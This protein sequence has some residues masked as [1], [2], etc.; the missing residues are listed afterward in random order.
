MKISAVIIAL[1]EEDRIREAIKTAQKVCD[2]VLVVDGG[3]RD[4]TA[5]RASEAGAVVIERPFDDFSAQK[6]FANSRASYSWILSLDSDERVSPELAEEI[7]AL[8]KATQEPA[9]TAY[10]FPRHTFYLGR[11]IRHCWYPD[12]KP[13]LFLKARVSWKG[14]LVHEALDIDGPVGS[15]H[16]PLFHYSYRD[17]SDH[18]RRIDFYTSRAARKLLRQ[19]RRRTL[20]GSTLLPLWAFLRF[21]IIR[22]GFLDGWPGFV[23]AA[24]TSYSVLLKYL[25]LRELLRRK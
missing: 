16:G 3:S 20:I 5:K 18:V 22:F 11:L 4:R 17:I 25:K 10:K 7:E 24:L 2:E 8:K 15:L 6:N 19:G 9:V 1:N 12:I 13:R 21:Y 14:E 23:I